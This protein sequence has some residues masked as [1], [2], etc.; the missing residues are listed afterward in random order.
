MINSHKLGGLKIT[1]MY[2]LTVLE[3][4][5]LTSRCEQ[6][7]FLAEDL[8]ENLFLT[9]LHLLVVTGSDCLVDVTLPSDCHLLAF[10]VSSVSLCPHFSVPL[11]IR[12]PFT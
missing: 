2:S 12:F 6:S 11:F 7:R 10:C 4:G 1:E 9:P 5:S 3:D 8:R